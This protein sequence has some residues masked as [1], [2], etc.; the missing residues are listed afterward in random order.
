MSNSF[1]T[2][3]RELFAFLENEYDF[4]LVSQAEESWGGELRYVC[5][6]RSVGV[7]L[8]YEYPSA[9]VFVFIYR[10]VQGEMIENESPV[11]E[12]SQIH[13]IDFNDVLQQTEKMRPAYDY[14]E[15]SEYFHPTEGLRNYVREFARRLHQYGKELL[16]GDF[17]QFA[18]VEKIIRRRAKS[19]A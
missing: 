15:S 9:F 12:T 10:L 14:P 19:D 7:R 16:A 11:D 1:V 4:V 6:K 2:V 17:R 18:A 5:A 13:Y 3:A 8:V